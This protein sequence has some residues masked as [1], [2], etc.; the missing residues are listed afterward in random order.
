MVARWVLR[1][2]LC[3]ASA[4]SE[5]RAIAM[6]SHGLLWD[7]GI[8]IIKFLTEVTICGFEHTIDLLYNTPQVT[9]KKGRDST[10]KV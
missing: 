5:A 6:R 10:L 7:V 3:A 4:L 2:I 8:N 1:Y 9:Q